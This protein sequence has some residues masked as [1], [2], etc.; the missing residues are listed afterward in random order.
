MVLAE[1][2]FSLVQFSLMQAR[3]RVSARSRCSVPAAESEPGRDAMP[4]PA[5]SGRGTHA[6]KTWSNRMPLVSLTTL[7]AT[8][9]ISDLN[10][11]PFNCGLSDSMR[12][13][14]A[15]EIPAE[16]SEQMSLDQYTP[17]RSDPGLYRRTARGRTKFSHR[18]TQINTDE[19]KE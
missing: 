8:S 15:A 5:S 14:I 17:K 9:P 10:V 13:V 12:T 11:T 3:A 6:R 19:S 7:G 2:T 18:W 4:R 16:S 1:V